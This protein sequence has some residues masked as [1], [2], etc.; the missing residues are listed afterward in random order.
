LTNLDDWVK[1]A[2]GSAS[3]RAI[4]EKLHRSNTTV[5]TWLRTGKMPCHVVIELARIYHADPVGGLLAAGYL[6][7]ED[8]MNGGLRN[9][10]HIAPTALLVAEL[11]SR[12][13]GGFEQAIESGDMW[14]SPG[15]GGPDGEGWGVK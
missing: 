11:H 2:T 5:A 9:A 10:V 4:A 3:A 14:K 13:S 1:T 15:G 7:R 12:H 6:N 8:L